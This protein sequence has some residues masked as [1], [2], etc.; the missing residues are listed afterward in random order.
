MLPELERSG[1][2]LGRSVVDTGL[3]TQRP[4]ELRT[5]HRTSVI[6]LPARQYRIAVDG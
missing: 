2:A 1:T 5:P 4:H 6:V 3:A